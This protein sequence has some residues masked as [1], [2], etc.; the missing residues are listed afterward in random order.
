MQRHPDHHDILATFE[1]EVARL[2]GTAAKPLEWEGQLFL[3]ATL[4]AEQ[5]VAPGDTIRHGVA[6][7]A[8][9]TDVTVHPY[10]FRLI[11]ANGAIH[12]DNV[13]S[14]RIAKTEEAWRSAAVDA[15]VRD[16]LR[17]CASA[18]SFRSNLSEME[19][20]RA[21]LDV[22]MAIAMATFLER[23]RDEA[24]VSR[25]ARTFLGGQDRSGFGLMNAVTAVARQ[26][27]R[28]DRRWRLESLGGGMLAVLQPPVPTLSGGVGRLLRRP[29]QPLPKPDLASCE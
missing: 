4:P 14:V 17:E 19:Q 8:T 10:T 24:T 18:P 3:R 15:Q 23:V 7:R 22:R 20:L 11:C 13:A 16:A 9:P 12:V 6:L 5:D 29:R 2:G 27:P 26:E 25:I 21:T 1:A 28:P